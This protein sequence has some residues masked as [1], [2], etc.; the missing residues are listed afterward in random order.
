MIFPST[1]CL[2]FAV[3]SLRSGAMHQHIHYSPCLHPRGWIYPA[4]YNEDIRELRRGRRVKVRH[5]PLSKSPGLIP[6]AIHQYHPTT[7]L[8]S[9]RVTVLPAVNPDR[10]WADWRELTRS[11]PIYYILRIYIDVGFVNY[12][13]GVVYNSNPIISIQTPHRPHVS[14]L[15]CISISPIV[16]SLFKSSMMVEGCDRTYL[17]KATA[18]WTETI[19]QSGTISHFP[20][21]SLSMDCQ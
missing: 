12:L 9:A 8:Q 17:A 14:S 20:F 15:F 2:T 16:S 5:V 3:T 10:D 7:H 1:S 21:L 6:L 13:Q 19:S 4:R 18:R 11:T